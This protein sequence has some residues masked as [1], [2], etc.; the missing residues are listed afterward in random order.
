MAL[1]E[2]P[3]MFK[4]KKDR[5]YLTLTHEEKRYLLQIM[6]WFRNKVLSE[7][8]PTEDIDAV[9]LKLAR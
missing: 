5:V 9:I 8:G 4:R 1:K 6:V 3:A 2:V 7:G